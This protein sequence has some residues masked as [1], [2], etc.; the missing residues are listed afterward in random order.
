[1]RAEDVAVI[2]SFTFGGPV[3]VPASVSFSIE[4]EATGPAVPRG[5]GGSVPATDPGAF[6]GEFAPALATGSFSGR[7]LAFSFRSEAG[8]STA[9]AYAE[10]GRERNGVFL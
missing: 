4:W 8:V 6:R 1:M 10:M 9:R 7:E 5:K 3:Q 2:D